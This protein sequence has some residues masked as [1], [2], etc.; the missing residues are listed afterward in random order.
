MWAMPKNS[1]A[2]SVIT[3][4]TG[5]GFAQALPIA[6]A[7]ILTLLYTPEDFRM[8]ALYASLCAMLTALVTGKYDLAI[9]VPKY[10][11]EA[12]NLVA[13]ALLL[14]FSISL[15]LVVLL[16][17]GDCTIVT[18]LGHPAIG[19]WLYLVPCATFILGCCYALKFWAN[20]HGQYKSI[21]VSRAV[22][23]GSAGTV[24]LIAGLSRVGL[25]G[26]IIGQLIGQFVSVLFFIFLFRQETHGWCGSQVR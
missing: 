19:P 21:A 3:L 6:L 11:R 26:L 10:E 16:L 1:C 23:S 7:P 25:A 15:L 9:V 14:S 5:T 12:I 18:L 8:F 17:V 24:Q 20:R 22:Q 2:K 4:M 13:L